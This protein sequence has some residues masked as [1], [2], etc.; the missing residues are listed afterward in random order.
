MQGAPPVGNQQGK[1]WLNAA[2]LGETDT[3]AALLQG[4]PA[5][6]HFE[7]QQLTKSAVVSTRQHAS[8]NISQESSVF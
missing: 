6:L 7:V 2:K 8:P 3:L 1:Q 4:N 5:L